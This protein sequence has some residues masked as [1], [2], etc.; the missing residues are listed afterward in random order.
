MTDLSKL[1]MPITSDPFEISERYTE[2][3]PCAPL[4][5]FIRCFWGTPRPV[6]QTSYSRLVIPDT[7]MDIIFRITDSKDSVSFCP[8]DKTSRFSACSASSEEYS[9]FAVR[10]YPWSAAAFAEYRDINVS[11]PSP[12]ELFPKLTAKLHDVVR[13]EN[14]LEARG[15]AAEAVLLDSLHCDNLR[16]DVMNALYYAI[17]SHGNVKISDLA[18]YTA[19]SERSLQRQFSAQTG[20]S[21]KALCSLIRY[22]LLWQ[23]MALGNGISILDAVLKYGYFDQAHLL[24]DF[25]KR[26]LMTPSEAMKY[27]S[28]R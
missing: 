10:F 25:K 22:Q 28:G 4:K 23:E 2:V 7:C 1:Y 13:R 14:T 27:L 12:E 15:K 24:N 16:P 6:R 9:V 26:H 11:F 8:I 20:I 21:P 19:L 18:A 3:L 5:P 17:I